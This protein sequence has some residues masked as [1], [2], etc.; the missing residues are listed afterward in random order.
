M[1]WKQKKN[2]IVK[3]VIYFCVFLENIEVGAN[4]HGQIW[5]ERLQVTLSSAY[6][7]EWD[8]PQATTP[9]TTHAYGSAARPLRPEIKDG[10]ILQYIHF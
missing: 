1:C 4:A 8:S 2:I 9:T 6:L 3:F 10:V 5:P 7:R